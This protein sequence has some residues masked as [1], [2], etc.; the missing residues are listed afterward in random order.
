MDQY[1]NISNCRICRSDQIFQVLKFDDQY[2]ASTFVKS[3]RDH[4][5]SNVKIPL[6]L[7]LCKVCGL[8]QLQETVRPDLLFH[9]YFYRSGITDTMRTD[10]KDVVNNTMSLAS[11]QPGDYVVDIGANDCTM[12]S[13]FP[14]YLRR[15][16]VEPAQNI[17][18][19]H[20]DKSIQVIN[21]YFGR[22]SLLQ[23]TQGEKVKIITATAMFY[24]LHDPN[25]ETRDIKFLLDHDGI[26]VIQV[27]DLSATIRDMN[28]YDIVHEHLEYY[29]L[30][31]I[32][33][34]MEKNGLS[35]FH[36]SKNFVNGGSLRI[37]VTHQENNAPKSKSFVDILAEEKQWQLREPDTYVQY[38]N[39]IQRL[40][41]ICRDFILNEIKN[42]GLVLG[43]GASTKGN[44]LLQLCGIDKDILPYISERDEEKVGLRTMGSDIEIISEYEARRMKPSAFLVIPWN[45]K[46]EILN[47]EQQ[48]IENGG[49]FLFLMPYPHYIDKEG[50]KALSALSAPTE[51]DTGV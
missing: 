4:P 31:S 6:T 51:D 17:H 45:F 37:F 9:N 44:V 14:D 35:V 30:D 8:V 49:K 48:Y 39:N 50:E 27:S 36:A 5:T 7:M 43:L 28:F 1:K 29:S 33:Y 13:M 3:N 25:K 41:K 18:W 46:A 26:G 20:L 38:S 16:A 12:I 2:I 11:I 22:D 10:L 23:V 42:G 34:L 40:A 32:N 15:I 21:D 19:D 47:R 24:D